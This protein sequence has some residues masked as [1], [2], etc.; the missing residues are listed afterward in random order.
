MSTR[1]RW[2]LRQG[3]RS[4]SGG[5]KV[6][7]AMTELTCRK[8]FSRRSV[9]CRGMC[10]STDAVNCG[11]KQSFRRHVV[12]FTI[13]ITSSLATCSHQRMQAA[14]DLPDPNHRWCSIT[15]GCGTKGSATPGEQRLRHR[16]GGPP[17]TSAPSFVV[18]PRLNGR[19][20]WGR[21]SKMRHTRR[22]PRYDHLHRLYL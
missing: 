19:N 5:A 1:E 12:G 17:S 14:L 13:S 6:Q 10:V 16:I 4:R 18:C 9:T 20:M 21:G 22:R 7:V 11:R 15:V 3:T 2:S 8:T